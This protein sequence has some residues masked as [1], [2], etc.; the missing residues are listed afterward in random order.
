MK[1]CNTS[2]IADK[3]LQ[4][5]HAADGTRGWKFFPLGGPSYSDINSLAA[6]LAWVVHENSTDTFDVYRI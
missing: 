6:R 1:N 2:V 3:D 4:L 5:T